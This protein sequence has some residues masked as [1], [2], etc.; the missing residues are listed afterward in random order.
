VI[1]FKLFNRSSCFF[2][3]RGPFAGLVVQQLLKYLFG[4][5]F[6]A[7]GWPDA[8]PLGITFPLLLS[9][10]VQAAGPGVSNASVKRS[11]PRQSTPVFKRTSSLSAII[12]QD[13]LVL[14][15]AFRHLT[16]RFA[17]KPQPGGSAQQHPPGNSIQIPV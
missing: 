4:L 14:G 12:L 3:M 9:D 5:A 1:Q 10:I 8:M 15:G 13:P 11:S 17:D 6:F 7:V 2:G 16:H